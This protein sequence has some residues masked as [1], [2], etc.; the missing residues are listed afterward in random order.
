MCGVKSAVFAAAAVV[1]MRAGGSS[2]ARLA[3]VAGLRL[4]LLQSLVTVRANTQVMVLETRLH[5]THYRD[6]TKM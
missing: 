4:L 6:V 3:G 2:A 1:R 5:W